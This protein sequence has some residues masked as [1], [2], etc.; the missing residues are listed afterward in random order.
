MTDRD[1]NETMWADDG[2]GS[3]SITF[4]Y[5][6]S[7]RTVTLPS[8]VLAVVARDLAKSADVTDRDERKWCDGNRAA[9]VSML[10]H[11]L[12]H[13]GYEGTGAEH[14]AWI[15]ER[16]AAVAKLRELCADFGDNDWPDDLHLGDVIE[17]HLARHLEA[18]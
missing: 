15:L 12:S 3:T 7:R 13:L 18:P 1:E 11:V 8:D 16:E 14:T 9:F 17:K 5:G 2:R 6:R 10:S 4:G